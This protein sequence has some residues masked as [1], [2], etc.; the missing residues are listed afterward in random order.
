VARTIENLEADLEVVPDDYFLNIRKLQGTL[1]GQPFAISNTNLLSG[2]DHGAYEPLRV[3][4]DDLNLGA[5]ILET[6]PAGIPLHIPGLMEGGETGWFNLAGKDSLEHFFVAGPWQRP[7][8]RGEVRVRNAN[9]TFPFAN[10][11][12]G[13]P[14]VQN[15]LNNI[16]WDLRALTL[17][18]T[19]YV[20]EFPTAVYVNMEVD[21]QNSALEFTGILKDSTFR[22]SGTV[23]STRG[24]FEYLDLNFRVEKFGAEFNPNSLYPLL[25]GK[26]WTVV[27]DTANVPNDVYLELYSVDDVTRQE[28]S[29]GRWDRVT[30]KLSSQYPGYEETQK[31]IMSTLGYSSS[32]M[33]EQA[34]RAVGYSTDKFI[35]RPIMRPIERQLERRLGL[36]VVRFSYAI[37]R[38]FLDANIKNEEFGSSWA[39]LR[40]SR[41]ILG[42]YLTD[43]IYVL[44]TG[45]LKAGVDYQ[46]Q[47]KG[48]GL[49]HIVGLEYRLNSRWLLQMEYDYNTLF[50]RHKD[51]KKIWLRHSFPF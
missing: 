32:N 27:R 37:A 35:F 17:K 10:T 11:G 38:N 2:L 47:N 46:Y 21:P 1:Q 25:Y 40:S 14:L 19:R 8:L 4:G 23:E 49:Q 12:E 28:V 43:D 15:I 16:D 34:T 36:D 50:E 13:S 22:I 41:L 3:G 44:Y 5:L 39:L 31:G 48:V 33:E 18:D 9:L 24:E 51:D 6:G 30:I 26:A 7:H 20:K 29:R 42:K 45:E